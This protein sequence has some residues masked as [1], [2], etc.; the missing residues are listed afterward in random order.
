M[1]NFNLAVRNLEL[2][3]RGYEIFSL[4]ISIFEIFLFV[5]G[6]TIEQE[7]IYLNLFFG[8]FIFSSIFFILLYA[9]RKK[10]KN[11]KKIVFYEYAFIMFAL[12]W[13]VLIS[14]LDVINNQG[15][16]VFLAMTTFLG[17]IVII[18]PIL[19]EVV[20]IIGTICVYIFAGKMEYLKDG[21]FFNFVT[22]FLVAGILCW[23]NYNS[24]IKEFKDTQKF[25]EL[26]YIDNLTKVKN[27]RAL[28]EKQKE[29]TNNNI[30][31][32]IALIDMDNFKSINDKFGHDQGDGALIYLA[33]NL[34]DK[35][36]NSVY[37][38]GGDEFVIY[39]Q[40]SYE[41]IESK[42]NV[43]NEALKDK[44]KNLEVNVQISCG[45]T[46]KEEEMEAEEAFW[47]ADSALYDV[48]N[49]GKGRIKII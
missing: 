22:F 17:G 16:T 27:R 38:Y 3:Y 6:I 35:F 46:Y 49:S 39:S 32:W 18:N 45:I 24:S 36:N 30:A 2:N 1:K 25:S 28:D 29:I 40:D 47:K 7:V 44:W 48:K 43:I 37:R 20:I 34:S 19:Y 31:C 33:Q 41:E 5:R 12:V 21:N 9:N 15:P 26:S 8:M 42:I 11:W 23:K 14:A 10:R 4:V 13:S